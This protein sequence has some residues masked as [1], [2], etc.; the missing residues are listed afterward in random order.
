MQDFFYFYFFKPVHCGK[1]SYNLL[2]EEII[3]VEN[4]TMSTLFS[5][6]RKEMLYLV[7]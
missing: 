7:G 4:L 2:L 6:H 3:L 1:V 5:L